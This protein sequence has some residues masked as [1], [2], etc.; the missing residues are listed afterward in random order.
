MIAKLNAIGC[1]TVLIIFA[2]IQAMLNSALPAFMIT[3]FHPAQRGKALAI[4]YSVSLTLFGGLMPYLILTRGLSVNPG[5]PI[6]ICAAFTLI[7]IH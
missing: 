2:I 1:I 4:S 6:S 7:V 5:I 3:Q